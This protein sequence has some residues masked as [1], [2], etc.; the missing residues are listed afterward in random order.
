MFKLIRSNLFFI[1]LILF[2]TF[3]GYPSYAHNDNAYYHGEKDLSSITE[4]MKH[5]NGDTQIRSISIPGTHESGARYGGDIK[6]NQT[7]TIEQQL[8]AGIRFLDIRL[9]IKK[10]GT[11]ALYHGPTYLKATF[12]EI[13]GDVKKFLIKHPSEFVFMRVKESHPSENKKLIFTDMFSPYVDL[14]RNTL[15]DPYP[16][17]KLDPKVDEVR[18]KIVIIQNF[19]GILEGLEPI[20]FSIQDGYKLK[21]NWDLY[22]KWSQIKTHI[23]QANNEQG[24]SIN[25]LSGSTG[26]FPYFVASG[27]SSHQTGAPRLLT[28]MT[29][30]GWKNSYIDFPRV[31]CGAAGICSIVFEGTNTLTKNF[32]NNNTNITFAGI[33]AADFPGAGL[34]RSILNL[35]VFEPYDV[36]VKVEFA[37][38]KCLTSHRCGKVRVTLDPQSHRVLGS[39]DSGSFRYSKNRTLPEFTVTGFKQDAN[40]QYSVSHI[41]K[42]VKTYANADYY[43]TVD[44]VCFSNKQGNNSECMKTKIVSDPDSD[45]YKKEPLYFPARS[46]KVTNPVTVGI[47]TDKHPNYIYL[48]V[49]VEMDKQ[50]YFDLNS[51]KFVSFKYHRSKNSDS[52]TVNFVANDSE[53]QFFEKTDKAKTVSVRDKY[54]FNLYQVCLIGVGGITQ[55]MCAEADLTDSSSSGHYK[56]QTITFLSQAG[57]TQP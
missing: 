31:N 45:E 9:R 14:Y 2:S 8:Q 32:L 20:T 19:L 18:G 22:H 38:V 1:L 13:L 3:I 17:Y 57:I 4:W 54:Y 15:W 44:E 11:L 48:D 24:N 16:F 26:S 5:L 42:K 52:V 39:P 29:T 47:R 28:G 34:I 49:I 43:F 50:R 33:V 37:M 56:E 10:D 41:N 7:L 40:K 36:P 55:P 53:E 35:N 46:S 21:N 6:K 25:Y 12:D 51:P 30:P 23:E 27:H